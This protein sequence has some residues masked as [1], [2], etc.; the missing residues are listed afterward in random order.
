MS[1]IRGGWRRRLAVLLVSTGLVVLVVAPTARADRGPT[2]AERTG[3]EQAA[4][5]EYGEPGVRV[6]VHDIKVSTSA[7]SWATAGVD[8]NY[9]ASI[10][11]YQAEFRRRDNG[12]WTGAGNEMP[13]A[14]EDDLGLSDTKGTAEKVGSIVGYV[15]VGLIAVAVLALIVWLLSKLGGGRPSSTAP[16]APPSA[17][18]GSTATYMP[19]K[20]KRPCPACG[21]RGRGIC[22]NCGGR[23]QLEVRDPEAGFGVKLVPCPACGTQG[24]PICSACGGRGWTEA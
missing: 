3:I 22:S 11:D 4:H 2:V 19:P 24:G 17:P 9:G 15:V 1:A 23:G 14:V 13:A 18:G 5:R 12:S 8:V 21:G 6:E 20:Q 10:Q 16:H 7:R